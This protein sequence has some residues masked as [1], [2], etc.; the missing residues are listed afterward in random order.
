M[1]LAAVVF[2][3]LGRVLARKAPTPAA[4]RTRLIICFG[5]SDAADDRGHALAGMR[6]GR[7]L[8]RL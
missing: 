3:H 1:M 8:F 5:L 7:E 6:A 2:A 4:K